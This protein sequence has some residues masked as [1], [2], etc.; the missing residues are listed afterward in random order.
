MK[1]TISILLFTLF[2]TALFATEIGWA[3]LYNDYQEGSQTASHEKYNKMAL[4]A[5]HR[6]I[7]F[8]TYITVTNRSNNQSVRVKINDRGPVGAESIV[9]LSHAAARALGITKD[10]TSL[11]AIDIAPFQEN[12]QPTTTVIASAKPKERVVEMK[13]KTQPTPSAEKRIKWQAKESKPTAKPTAKP[14]AKPKE[15]VTKYVAKTPASANIIWST[16]PADGYELY[17]IRG[18]KL[19]R[20]GYGVQLAASAQYDGIMRKVADLQDRDIDEMMISV[21]NGAM[22]LGKNYKLILGPFSSYQEA[23]AYRK[24]CVKKGLSGAFVVNIAD[25][26]LKN[27][28]EEYQ[29]LR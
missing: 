17:Q 11:V 16:A 19:E 8:G 10:G 14:A 22:G 27:A 4:T 13:V 28:G 12:V 25:K 15:K 24:V 6:T 29:P 26:Y 23:D 3:S 7:K 2:N 5:G 18:K 20:E 21:E 9:L 1:Y